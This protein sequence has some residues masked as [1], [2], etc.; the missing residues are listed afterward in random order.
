MRLG[1]G[2]WGL[3]IGAPDTGATRERRIT[4]MGIFV[5]DLAFRTR[6]LPAWG[7]TVTGAEY[8]LSPGGKGFNQAVAAA[9]LGA[10][11][12]F[13]GKIGRDAFGQMA[14]DLWRAEGIDAR[15]CYEAPGEPSGAA[16]IVV[17][18]ATG[19]N[20]IIGAPGASALLTSE[21]VDRAADVIGSSD[22]FVTQLELAPALAE[23]ALGIA[24]ARG[25]RTILNAAPAPAP[26]RRLPR[27]VYA[28]C[29]V[30][31]PN[32]IEAAALTGRPVRSRADAARAAAIL[33]ARGAGAVVVTLGR[34]G[35]LAS[36]GRTTRHVPALDAGPVV[37]ATGAGDAFTGALAVALAEGADLLEATRFATAAAAISVTRHGTARAMP[38]RPEVDALLAR[39]S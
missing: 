36:D 11:V 20:A 32:E 38:A 10:R 30:I 35:A 33:L 31:T 6:R 8:R 13:I 24:R 19:D 27:R 25:V 5:A 9:R 2:T 37:E 15:F 21:E 18:P 28:L 39:G 16:A 34:R 3:G 23:H 4:V 22:V 1:V 14:R 17:Q 29:D 12:S 26:P 7:Q